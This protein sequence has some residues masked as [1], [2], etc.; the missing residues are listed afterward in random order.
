VF[1]FSVS[2]TAKLTGRAVKRVECEK[3]RAV[4][5]YTLERTATAT[6][7]APFLLRLWSIE[8]LAEE[9]AEKKLVKRL[10]A[11]VDP[12]PCPVCGWVQAEMNVV[13]VE[14]RF[15]WLRTAPYYLILI[16]LVLYG[17]F[18]LLTVGLIHAANG[19]DYDIGNAHGWMFYPAIPG[20]LAGPVMYYVWVRRRARR[21]DMNERI[22]EGKRI[23]EGRQRAVLESE[24]PDLVT[25]NRGGRSAA[26]TLT[27]PTGERTNPYSAR[28][29]TKWRSRRTRGRGESSRCRMRG[30]IP[31]VEP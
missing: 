2:S 20:A 15:G 16:T 17:I 13:E 8:G 28:T 26:P 14:R 19:P 21:F 5:Q 7:T 24:P 12:V 3:C 23:A 6:R 9:A 29:I 22:P 27:H 30:H 18:L 11:A 25:H 10:A 4:Y 31:G 1:Y